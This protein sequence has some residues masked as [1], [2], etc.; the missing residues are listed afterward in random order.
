MRLG[1]PVVVVRVAISLGKACPLALTINPSYPSLLTLRQTN[2][3]VQLNPKMKSKS[4]TILISLSITLIFVWVV[5]LFIV[6]PTSVYV[7]PEA[8]VDKRSVVTD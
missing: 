5:Y 7:E 6:P 8:Q 2:N 1:W 3:G 4:R